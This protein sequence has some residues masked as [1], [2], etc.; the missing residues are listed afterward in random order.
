MELQKLRIEPQPLERFR[1][2]L[3]EGA[4]ALYEATLRR[5]ALELGSRV[6]RD[7]VVLLHDPQSAGLAPHLARAGARVLWRCHIGSD[8]PGP[9]VEAGWRFLEPYLDAVEAYVF[10]R[11]SYVPDR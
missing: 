6:R 5:N 9:E 2:V 8:R 1:E 11:E 10:T 4:R 7:D 3:D